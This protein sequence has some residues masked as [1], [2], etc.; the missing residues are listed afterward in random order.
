M[1]MIP[2][3]CD[4][5]GTMFSSGIFVENSSNITFSAAQ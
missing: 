2:A 1:P 3:I 5:C 4:R